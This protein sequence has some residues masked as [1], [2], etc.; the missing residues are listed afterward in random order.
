MPHADAPAAPPSASAAVPS[1]AA[2]VVTLDADGR[3]S[4]WS[5]AAA[6]L[7]GRGE[8]DVLGLPAEE[9]GVPG[10]EAW[11]PLV[12]LVRAGGGGRTGPV[13]LGERWIDLVAVAHPAHEGAVLLVAGDVTERVRAERHALALRQV[14]V[15][16][17]GT[18]DAGEIVALLRTH[19]AALLSADAVH[20]EMPARE[21]RS[22][23]DAGPL[24]PLHPALLRRLREGRE[25]V[26]VGASGS[27]DGVGADAGNREE[28]ALPEGFATLLLLPLQLDGGE[29]GAV[30]LGWRGGRE[31]DGAARGLAQEMAERAA[32]AL[33]H[34]ARFDALKE[35]AVRR[36]R[37]FSA[38]SHDLRT[39]IT[40]IVG[41][42]EL[43]G[44]GIVGPL[45]ERQLEMVERISQVAGHLSQLVNDI[46]D[47]AKLDAGRMEF[48]RD[49]VPLGELV[50]DAVVTVRPQ[51]LSK[52]LALRLELGGHRYTRVLVD[53]SRVRQILVNLLSNAVKFTEQGTVQV[54]AGVDG[55]RGWIAVRD[56]G[57]G[58]PAGS[59]EVV[60]EEFLQLASGNKAKREPG[61]GLGLA[62]S[63]RLARAMGGD[64]T[65]SN[66]PEG[67]A[68]FTLV[69]LPADAG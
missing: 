1:A 62:I 4:A 66:A 46:L 29:P 36:E 32:V 16:L 34:A 52:G 10:A 64:L 25:A 59:E 12:E 3:V 58:L 35:A 55:E 22:A 30:V 19:A 26:L 49:K 60:F 57:P 20:V 45:E 24:G 43:L 50:E 27:D 47:L 9:A 63:R 37:F 38:M 21:S 33:H 18:L 8:G 56:T 51:A 17:A 42:S 2:A 53:A 6:E 13:A 61:S 15:E 11:L 40:A 41:Y 39:P 68:V 7:F 23:A 69:L 48:A 54:S 28:G 67:G 31:L 14:A 5:P 65:A 44:D